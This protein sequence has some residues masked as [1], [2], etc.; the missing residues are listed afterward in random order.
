MKHLAG[1]T[2]AALVAGTLLGVPHAVD[3]SNDHSQSQHKAATIVPTSVGKAPWLA[4]DGKPL[5]LPAAFR[6]KS[7]GGVVS[8][9]LVFTAGKNGQHGKVLSKRKLKVPAHHTVHTTVTGKV[10]GVSGV[11]RL[12]VCV[13]PKPTVGNNCRF[14]PGLVGIAATGDAYAR[15]D[16]AHSAGHVSNADVPLFQMYAAVQDSRLPKILRGKVTDDPHSALVSLAADAP[17][18]VE[19]AALPYFAPPSASNN[20]WTAGQRSSRVS[21][22]ERDAT[23]NCQGFETLSN[24]PGNQDFMRSWESVATSDGNALVWYIS[25]HAKNPNDQ[26]DVKLAAEWTAEA[27]GD[28]TTYADAM[29]HIWSKLTAQFGEPQSDAGESCYHGPDDRLDVYVSTNVSLI[30]KANAFDSLD[31]A[32]AVPYPAVGNYP[33]SGAWCTDRPAF[34]VIAGKRD[35][36]VLA[37]E[38]MHVLQFSHRYATCKAPISF[39]DE[40]GADWAGD[41]VYPSSQYELTN[42][43]WLLSSPTVFSSA[44]SPKAYQYWAFW[45]ML[46]RNEGID[47]LNSVFTQLQSKQAL[48]AV[49]AAIPGGWA[50]QLPRLA[51]TVWNQEPIGSS[52]WPIDEG[53]DTWDNWTG[54]PEASKPVDA[55]LHG[56]SERTLPLPRASSLETSFEPLSIG[57]IQEVDVNDPKVRE[58]QFQNALAS[59][60]AHVDAMVQYADGSWE[61]KDWSGKPQVTMCLDDMDQDI[62][63]F[64]VLSTNVS[65]KD[66]PLFT[67]KVRLRS[68]CGPIYVRAQASTVT[69]SWTLQGTDVCGDPMTGTANET[70]TSGLGEFNKFYGLLSTS[71]SALVSSSGDITGSD[72]LSG[73]EYPGP[74]PCTEITS[75]NG[76]PGGVTATLTLI[77]G[78]QDVKVKWETQNVASAISLATTACR[79]SS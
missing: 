52:G 65:T 36:F 39:W 7:H 38:F 63:K 67:H 55:S 31:V 24:P 78:G 71:Q 47:V 9:G 21:S 20:G 26:L 46:E 28:A 50:K 51:L 34:I 62:Q 3:A 23:P 33:V 58:I 25:F 56:A 73:C 5:A 54:T 32:A 41:Y 37:H 64:V 18:A 74:T 49:D 35:P 57:G 79:G 30:G 29:P 59:K 19:S 11:G 12:A 66:L 60:P 75:H 17:A 76:E 22:S 69:G 6:A 72:S 68:S 40:G 27:L 70:V 48:A 13:D 8:V 15:I 2:A 1:I 4:V 10:S 53:F 45:M 61:L 16:A 42:H 43:K 77:N 44:A 14:A